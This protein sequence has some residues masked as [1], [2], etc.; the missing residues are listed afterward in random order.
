MNQLSLISPFVELTNVGEIS[1][2][3]PDH[4]FY[5]DTKKQLSE[6][7]II[8]DCST[9]M[10]M[11]YMLD[12]M[13]LKSDIFN[14]SITDEANEFVC[15]YGGNNIAGQKYEIFK[16]LEV[17]DVEINFYPE[18]GCG[19]PTFR[20]NYNDINSLLNY[21]L[22]KINHKYKSKRV[23]TTFILSTKKKDGNYKIEV[24]EF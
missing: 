15:I 9:D 16:N 10:E 13:K 12:R 18:A 8:F 3:L 1:K 7:D 17:E 23:N 5:Y 14:L 20:A 11:A 24:N 19:Y 22:N 4:S 21:S 2:S 6:Y